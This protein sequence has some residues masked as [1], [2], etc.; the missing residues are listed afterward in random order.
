MLSMVLYY[1][2]HTV[3]IRTAVIRSDVTTT[4]Y[5]WTTFPLFL[6]SLICSSCKR[7]PTRGASDARKDLLL[8][9]ETRRKREK[10]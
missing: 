3:D 2:I 7:R 9:L 8:N 4:H 5:A 10:R 1:C 6:S